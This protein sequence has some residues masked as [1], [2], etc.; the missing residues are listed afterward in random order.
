MYITGIVTNR[1]TAVV[2][3]LAV[4][5]I[6]GI[7]SSTATDMGTQVRSSFPAVLYTP[8]HYLQGILDRYTQIQPKFMFAEIEVVYAGNIV[9]LL[10]KV[11]DVVKNLADKGLQQ[12]ILLPSRVSG[13]ELTFVNMAKRCVP[14]LCSHHFA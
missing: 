5:S 4:A 10:P 11:A 14:Y 1:T 3:A 13:K 9:D 8:E 12:A 2:I 7:F 6:G